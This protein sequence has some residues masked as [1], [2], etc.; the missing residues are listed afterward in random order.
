MPSFDFIY[1]LT[2]QLDKQKISYAFIGFSD[3]KDGIQSDLFIDIKKDGDSVHFLES[4]IDA[5]S[6]AL[7][8]TPPESMGDAFIDGHLQNISSQGF[9]YIFSVFNEKNYRYTFNL[10][11]DR[12]VLA[13]QGVIDAL[14]ENILSDEDKKEIDKVL[15][16]LPEE[17]KKKR[18][19][20]K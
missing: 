11:A 9:F 5:Q 3:I 1:D 15:E 16:N 4:V 13:A 10:P 14:L 8:G 7:K 6:D 20:K 17:P 19:K 18:K 12:Y 2:A